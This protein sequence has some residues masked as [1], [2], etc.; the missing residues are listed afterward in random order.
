MERERNASQSLPRVAMGTWRVWR[1]VSE[2]GLAKNHHHVCEERSP[3]E[4]LNL[5][6]GITQWGKWSRKRTESSS[7]IQKGMVWLSPSWAIHSRA[8]CRGRKG[9]LKKQTNVWEWDSCGKRACCLRTPHQLRWHMLP[10][11]MILSALGF[12]QS[13]LSQWESLF[14][15]LCILDF[16]VFWTESFQNKQWIET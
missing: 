4:C 1:R 13:L 11:S 12:T 7:R 3:E 2:K 9:G 15:F 16:S 14:G 6:V 5:S 8:G 10:K